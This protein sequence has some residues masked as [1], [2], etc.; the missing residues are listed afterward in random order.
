MHK[1]CLFTSTRA[2]WGLLRGVAEL[3]RQSDELQLKLLV[4]G[5]HLSEKYGKTVREIEADGFSVDVGVDI[6]KFDDRPT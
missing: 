4:S 1:I 6:L 5:S 3:I 2:D